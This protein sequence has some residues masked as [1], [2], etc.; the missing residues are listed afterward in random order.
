MQYKIICDPTYSAVEVSLKAGERVVSDSGVMAW[1]S[2]NIKG[3]TTTRGGL[4]AG[5]KRKLLAGES[6]FQN[7]YS[8]QG[9]PGTI[10]FAPGSCG[11]YLRHVPGGW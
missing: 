8:P 9:G 1:M 11:R 7:V 3:E 6:F 5:M 2:A 10:T 4:M